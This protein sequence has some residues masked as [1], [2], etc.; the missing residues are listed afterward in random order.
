MEILAALKSELQNQRGAG[1]PI[2]LISPRPPHF[3]STFQNGHFEHNN[4]GDGSG[5]GTERNGGRHHHKPA[6]DTPGDPYGP[7]L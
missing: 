6:A 2:K 4:H 1:I 3:V 7:M 5:Y